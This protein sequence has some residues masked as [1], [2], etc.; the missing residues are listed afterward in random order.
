M[1]KTPRLQAKNR[2]VMSPTGDERLLPREAGRPVE[3][4]QHH[5]N[6][7]TSSRWSF[8]LT[9]PF[10]VRLRYGSSVCLPDLRCDPLPSRLAGRLHVQRSIHMANSFHFA[11]T[12]KLA[13]RTKMSKM[14]T[15]MIILA[16][17]FILSKCL[18]LSSSSYF[19]LG[20]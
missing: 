12:T 8:N 4:I 3:F 7:P 14:G 6:P 10:P 20:G 18:P 19:K 17:R 15:S 11:R 5:P 9:K 16:I 13:W 2:G 1:M